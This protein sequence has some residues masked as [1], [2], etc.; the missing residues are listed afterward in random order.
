MPFIPL[1]CHFTILRH[2]NM[3]NMPQYYTVVQGKILMENGDQWIVESGNHNGK[4]IPLFHGLTYNT[5]KHFSHC[6]CSS[7]SL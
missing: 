1:Q 5:S 2:E 6:K 7:S 4:I 3:Q